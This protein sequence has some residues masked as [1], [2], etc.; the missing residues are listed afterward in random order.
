MKV[1]KET[2][3]VDVFCY[4]VSLGQKLLRGTRKYQYLLEL[5]NE[6]VKKLESDVG[7]L[8]MK[9]ASGMVQRLSSGSQVQKL[10]SLAMEA[11][12]KMV[13]PPLASVSGQGYFSVLTYV[14]TADDVDFSSC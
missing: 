4:R 13:S 6:A 5:M 10:C 14:L 8:S 7:P 9:M 2:Q 12:D 1:A 3:R 11:V